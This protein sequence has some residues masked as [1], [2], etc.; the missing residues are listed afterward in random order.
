MQI[1][2]TKALQMTTQEASK[3]MNSLAILFAVLALGFG[4]WAFVD[5]INSS[6][7]KLSKRDKGLWSIAFILALPITTIVWAIVRK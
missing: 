2:T 6:R 3:D 1:E 7:R 5:M 4:I